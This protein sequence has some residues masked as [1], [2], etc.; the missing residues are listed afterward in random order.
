MIHRGKPTQSGQVVNLAAARAL[1]A[2]VVVRQPTT[3]PRS[4]VYVG[5][6]FGT[7]WTKV[8]VRES[9]SDRTYLV[10][11]NGKQLMVPSVIDVRA[12]GLL[13][14]GR[15]QQEANSCRVRY[16]KMLLAGVDLRDSGLRVALQRSKL[17]ELVGTAPAL[18]Q[19]VVPALC[20]V[21]VAHTLRLTRT[22]MR[23]RGLWADSQ[24][25]VNLGAPVKVADSPIVQVFHKVLSVA[26]RW[27]REDAIPADLD[28]AILRWR[29]DLSRP[30]EQGCQVS[31]E[32]SA[33]YQPLIRHHAAREDVSV[34]V[35][36][37]GG[38]VEVVAGQ[39]TTCSGNNQINAF[40]ADLGNIGVQ[41]AANAIVSGS[42]EERCRRVME[43]ASL[44]RHLS[45]TPL[46]Q[47]L[48]KD[49]AFASR[50]INE[51][52]RRGGREWVDAR[53][54]P[55]TVFLTG[56]GARAPLY[57]HRLEFLWG[58]NLYP[59][60]IRPLRFASLPAPQDVER[61]D[62][63]EA[64]F[65]RFSIAY[66]LAVLGPDVVVK[67]PTHFAGDDNWLQQQLKASQ[68][69]AARKHF[70]HASDVYR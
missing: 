30:A 56:G 70:D 42:L 50:T 13:A 2:P 15:V 57:G 1:R 64:E 32:L 58:R 68:T 8:A 38:T 16:L 11:L 60:G 20:A 10:S 3:A 33:A 18:A 47:L 31:P 55:I 40:S 5:L 22:A 26:C 39:F 59:T 62:V 41:L 49:F 28:S 4:L 7:S 14:V 19:L 52:K 6:D 12:D 35:D 67:A 29:E 65:H 34:L 21:F 46:G 17:S 51:G 69:V 66:G 53:R 63:P 54:G 27:E 23:E 37:G 44:M 43:D 61:S 25:L 45:T 24:L 48:L 9:A 36:V